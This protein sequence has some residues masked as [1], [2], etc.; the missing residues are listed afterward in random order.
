VLRV[1]EKSQIQALNRTQPVLPMGLGYVEGLPMNYVRHGTTTL[2]AA[3]H[4]ATGSVFTECK[5]RHRHQECLAFLRRLD[6]CIA[7]ELD[8]HLIV[9]HY[10]TR[11]H[12]KVRTW[13]AQRPRYQIHFTPTYLSWLN[14]VE[15]WFAL[16]TQPAIRCGSF[17]S[18]KDLV[19]KIDAFVQHCNRSHRPFAWT[20]TA[21]SVLGNAARLC[22]GI[23]WTRH[24]GQKI[25]WLWCSCSEFRTDSRK[26]K[27]IRFR[28]A[29]VH[30]AVCSENRN[31]KIAECAVIMLKNQQ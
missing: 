30:A 2:F 10:T 19:E 14:Q 29:A 31:R 9:D 16:I 5:P 11:K 4:V 23:S 25:K 3:L 7:P 27:V 20:A 12:P 26:L 28:P 24:N 1:D 8:V 15:R 6:Q 21:D 13:L 18:V 22:S 17:R